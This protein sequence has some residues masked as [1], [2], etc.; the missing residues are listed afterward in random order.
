MKPDYC[1]HA[2]AKCLRSIITDC[3]PSYLSTIGNNLLQNLPII[4]PH[5]HPLY[6]LPFL[7]TMACIYKKKVDI[8]L[9]NSVFF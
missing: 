1:F 2:K 7:K 4:L 9:G 5:P 3:A 8:Y 6:F